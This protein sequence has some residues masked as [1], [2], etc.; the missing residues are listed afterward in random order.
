MVDK[1]ID[2]AVEW[3]KTHK[4]G[5]EALSKKVESIIKE[6]LDNEGINYHSVT[7]RPK[8]VD[9]FKKKALKRLM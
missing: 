6:V 2:A 3:Y 5:Y 1:K 4:G 8:T 7:S 9:S